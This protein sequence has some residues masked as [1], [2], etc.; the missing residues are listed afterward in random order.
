M[1]SVTSCSLTIYL[2]V[3]VLVLEHIINLP[4][5]QNLIFLQFVLGIFAV[6]S[7]LSLFQ[8]YVSIKEHAYC[9]L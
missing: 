7:L 4:L 9:C 2:L 1:R 5:V 8:Q 3:N 6:T